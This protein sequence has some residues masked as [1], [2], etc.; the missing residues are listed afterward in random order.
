MKMNSLL[1]K[2]ETHDFVQLV[3][4]YQRKVINYRAT[5]REVFTENFY[6]KVLIF[7]HKHNTPDLYKYF[8]KVDIESVSARS[9]YAILGSDIDAEAEYLH[10]A[11]KFYNYVDSIIPQHTPVLN[12][13]NNLLLQKDTSYTDKLSMSDPQSE[14]DDELMLEEVGKIDM[15][16]KTNNFQYEEFPNKFAE[17]DLLDRQLQ[18]PNGG[19]DMTFGDFGRTD[20]GGLSGVDAIG[21]I[22]K[23]LNI[24]NDL[25][26]SDDGD[27]NEYSDHKGF[28]FEQGVASLLPSD[29]IN[30]ERSRVVYDR[31][32]E[33]FGDRGSE[34]VLQKREEIII[35]TQVDNGLIDGE[36]DTGLDQKS[37]IFGESEDASESDLENS[38]D[39][40]RENRFDDGRLGTVGGLEK[41]NWLYMCGLPYEFESIFY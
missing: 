11:N 37:K 9:F 34:E 32:K 27:G 15:T 22:G 33:I 26:L 14:K 1:S 3:D 5:R 23:D 31:S 20:F 29:S 38:G 16:R 12:A 2:E 7:F 13:D 8:L 30:I 17:V 40:D 10:N 25:E 39:G 28:G 18:G 6:E 35:L 36:E 41:S 19:L 24:I 4:F 21:G